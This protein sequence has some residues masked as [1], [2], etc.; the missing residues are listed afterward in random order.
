VSSE[1]SGDVAV[2]RV[3]KDPQGGNVLHFHAPQATRVEMSGDFTQW[4]PV[5]LLRSPD[6]WWSGAVP[7]GAGTYQM[8]LRVDGGPWMVPPGMLSMKDEFGGVTG[9]LVIE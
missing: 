2:F 7:A 3:V 4:A 9:L 5:D 8:N 6:G 1:S